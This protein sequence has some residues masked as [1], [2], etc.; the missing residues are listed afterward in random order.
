MARLFF[1]S[2]LLVICSESLY[3]RKGGNFGIGAVL[4]EPTGLSFKYWTKGNAN[5]VSGAL[6]IGNGGWSRYYDKWGRSYWYDNPA[7]Y[8][9]AAYLWHNTKAVPVNSGTMPLYGGVG[10]RLWAGHYASLGVRGCGG[11][12]YLPA[13]IPFDFF[14]ELGLVIDFI[15]HVGADMDA[16][17]GARFFF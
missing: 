6:A 12:E 9:Q 3:A 11:I 7:L 4:G 14:F 1:L 17:L 2:M 16:G 13:T 8:L 15:G 5:A 10:G